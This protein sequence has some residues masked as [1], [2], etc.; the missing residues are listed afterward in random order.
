MCGLP[1][2]VYKNGLLPCSVDEWN[3]ILEKK[4]RVPYILYPNLCAYCGERWPK[5][6]NVSDEEW[7]KYVQICERH[8]LLCRPCYDLIK[9]LI[10]TNGQPGERGE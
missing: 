7:D 2:E 10:D 8:Q 9:E 4:G 5:M 3:R 6:F 1:E